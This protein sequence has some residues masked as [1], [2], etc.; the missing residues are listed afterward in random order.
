MKQA[1]M[2]RVNYSC[3]EEKT[4]SVAVKKVIVHLVLKDAKLLKNYK[5]IITWR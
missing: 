4:A 1:L 3:I 5:N 2:P